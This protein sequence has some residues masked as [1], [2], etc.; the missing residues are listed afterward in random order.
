MDFFISLKTKMINLYN[1]NIY[2]SILHPFKG[3]AE[4]NFKKN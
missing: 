1:S 3:T 4:P 2:N